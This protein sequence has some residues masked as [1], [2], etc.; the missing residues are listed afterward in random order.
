MQMCY[1]IYSKKTSW[2]RQNGDWLVGSSWQCAHSNH[3]ICGTICGHEW[4][5]CSPLPSLF[6]RH[7]SWLLQNSEDE[8]EAWGERLINV[9]EIPE[10]SWQVLYYARRVSYKLP[11]VKLLGCSLTPK[12]STLKGTQC[13]IKSLTWISVYKY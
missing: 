2:E 3:P 10:I 11:M 1:S 9:L 7:C 5:G 4:N 12:R 13:K 6:S 8:T